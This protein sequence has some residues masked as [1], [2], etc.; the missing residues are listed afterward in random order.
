MDAIASHARSHPGDGSGSTDDRWVSIR[1]IERTD[2]PGLSDFY[3]RLSPESCR[4]RF[5][6]CAQVP[7]PLI[8]QLA[9]STGLVGILGEPGR[10]DGAI[11][12]HASIQP[13]GDGGGEVAFAVGGM[14]CAAEGSADVSSPWRSS[15][16][17]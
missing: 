16:R 17:S 9:E 3:A 1:P 8:G 4:R 2:A 6:S 11:V 14:S 10:N 12:A 7:R 15:A 5:L 13:N